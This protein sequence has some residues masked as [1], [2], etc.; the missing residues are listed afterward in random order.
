MRD[1]DDDGDI[2]DDDILGTLLPTSTSTVAVGNGGARVSGNRV[3][4]SLTWG[5]LHR[6]TS[7]EL[8]EE[9][10]SFREGHPLTMAL[11]CSL[12]I[13]RVSARLWESETPV[14]VCFE[15]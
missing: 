1:V 6:L 7:A 13:G 12:V 9:S 15:V 4:C 5:I 10:G 8:R 14:S 3:S 2:N 11:G